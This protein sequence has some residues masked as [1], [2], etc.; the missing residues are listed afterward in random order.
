MEMDNIEQQVINN[1]I[2]LLT[3]KL[4]TR[5]C[6]NSYCYSSNGINKKYFIVKA[7]EL[8]EITSIYGIELYSTEDFCTKQFKNN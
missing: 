3:R 1:F 4:L 8:R 2:V 6:E 5:L 7:E